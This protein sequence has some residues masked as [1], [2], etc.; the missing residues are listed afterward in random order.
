MREAAARDFQKMIPI[1]KNNA[2]TPGLIITGVYSAP[3]GFSATFGTTGRGWV[4]CKGISAEATYKVERVGNQL[5]VKLL[6]YTSADLLG[7]GSEALSKLAPAEQ[8]NPTEWQRQRVAFPVLAD[9]K[10]SASGTIR[11][12]G[13]VGVGTRSGTKAVTETQHG[14]RTRTLTPG[15]A[16][17]ARRAGAN[18]VKNGMTYT[19]TEPTTTEMTSTVPTSE[20]AY[21]T[22]T[23]TCPLAPMVPTGKATATAMGTSIAEGAGSALQM[24]FDVLGNKNPVES[25]ANRIPDPGLRMDGQYAGQDGFDVEFYPTS[26][27]IACRDAAVSRDYTVSASAGHVLVNIQ[28]GATQLVLELRPDGTLTGSGSVKVDGRI[29]TGQDA[30][31]NIAFRPVTDTC[32]V[33]VLT[34][35]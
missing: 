30:S 19:I 2:R 17:A 3:G 34:P 12:T 24:M 26:A 32:R 7:Y 10:L 8:M 31:G 15:E 20:T 18:P 4:T 28:N 13:Q 25:A 16:D 33:G 29:V 22:R 23:V 27:V 1:S 35:K 21:E 5:Q 11:V 14:T 6:D 9:G